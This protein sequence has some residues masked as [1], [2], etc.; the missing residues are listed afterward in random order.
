[1][2]TFDHT[3]VKI[4]EEMTK[5]DDLRWKLVGETFLTRL[6]T[7]NYLYVFELKEMIL[8]IKQDSSVLYETDVNEEFIDMVAENCDR[9]VGETQIDFIMFLLRQKH[10]KDWQ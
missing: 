7:P 6:L 2:L 9:Q 3:H 1:M 8:A 10:D 5:R 4:I